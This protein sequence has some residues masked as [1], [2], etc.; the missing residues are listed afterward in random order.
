MKIELGKCELIAFVFFS[1]ISAVE[2]WAIF[3]CFTESYQHL[4]NLVRIAVFVTIFNTGVVLFTLKYKA[5][6][7]ALRNTTE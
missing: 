7:D 5:T 4:I 1:L 6:K 2:I 3:S